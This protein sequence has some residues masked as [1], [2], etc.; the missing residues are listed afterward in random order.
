M[1]LDVQ[2]EWLGKALLRVA[3]G[4]AA[5]LKDVYEATS[6]K[7][8]GICLRILREPAEAEDVLQD[9]YATIWRKAAAFDAT[10]A[11]PI[12]CLATIARNRAIDR[13][14]ARPDR[15]METMESALD[16]IDATP[17]AQ[18]RIEELQDVDRLYQCLNQLEENRR[19]VIRAAFLDGHTYDAL[20][21][22]A[23]VPLGTMKSWIR[24]SLAQLTVCLERG[25][26]GTPRART[27]LPPIWPPSSCLG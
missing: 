4:D 16:V 9:V 14:R 7:L 3:D 8:F 23:G 6:S 21:R 10:R 17:S 26:T 5:A 1:D 20:A 11:S 25:G 13:L 12:T 18:A 24:R 27:T 2:R 19:D 15:R 22:R